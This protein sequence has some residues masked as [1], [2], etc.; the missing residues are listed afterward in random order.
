V[1]VLDRNSGDH[2]ELSDLEA[3][4]PKMKV[5]ELERY[6]RTPRGVP[7]AEFASQNWYCNVCCL[8]PR[9]KCRNH[10]AGVRP[11]KHRRKCNRFIKKYG[12]EMSKPEVSHAL[13]PT[14]QTL[15]HT[16]ATFSL[17]ATGE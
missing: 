10:E 3:P 13:E 1:S 9:P 6:A 17:G 7:K 12:V 5:S 4:E 16:S 14:G 8:D 15:S 11:L 2:Y